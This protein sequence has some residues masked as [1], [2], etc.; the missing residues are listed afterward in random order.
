MAAVQSH[1]GSNIIGFK[2]LFQPLVDGS[3]LF[4]KQIIFINHSSLILFQFAPVLILS[5]SIFNWTLL[6]VFMAVEYGTIFNL[7]SINFFR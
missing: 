1:L 3:K 5:I 7:T 6:P 4:G 2:G